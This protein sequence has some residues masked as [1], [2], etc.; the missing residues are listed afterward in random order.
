MCSLRNFQPF[1]SAAGDYV[2]RGGRFLLKSE[3]QSG[4]ELIQESKALSFLS[5]KVGFRGGGFLLKSEDQ[6][7]PEIQERSDGRYATHPSTQPGS[8][9]S[10]E[11]CQQQRKPGTEKVG[12]YLNPRWP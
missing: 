2:S 9:E 4:P 6:S 5:D 11:W 12:V 1:L 8:G 7:C 10:A 3:D